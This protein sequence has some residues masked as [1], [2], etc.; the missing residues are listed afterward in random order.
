MAQGNDWYVSSSYTGAISNGSTA[1]P[2]KTL[3]AVSSAAVSGDGIYLQRGDVFYGTLQLGANNI[4]ITSYG[5]PEKPNPKISGL[6]TLDSADFVPSTPL[7]NNFVWKCPLASK[8]T[9]VILNGELLEIGRNPDPESS[10]SGYYTYPTWGTDAT[11]KFIRASTEGQLS[12]TAKQVVIR[13]NPSSIET[14]PVQNIDINNLKIYYQPT[15][16][17]NQANYAFD[18]TNNFGYYFQ[19]DRNSLSRNGEWY[20]DETEQFLYVFFQNLVPKTLQVSTV[21]ILCNLPKGGSNI[22]ITGI[23]F[24]G[25]RRM[26]INVGDTSYN[27]E[28][29]NIHITSC[30]F[31]YIGVRGIRCRFVRD[32]YVKDC[33]FSNCLSGGIQFYTFLFRRAQPNAQVI[34]C[35]FNNIAPWPGMAY[36]T[37]MGDNNAICTYVSTNCRIIGNKFTDVGKAAIYWQGDDVEI[38]E[39]N[40][41]RAMKTYADFGAIYTWTDGA[42]G[43]FENRTIENNLVYDCPGN[44][45]GTPGTSIL[46]NGIYLDGNTMN[47]LVKNNTVFNMPNAGILA[48]N[49]QNITL[50]DNTLYNNRYGI[51]FSHLRDW[52]HNQNISLLVKHNNIYSARGQMNTGLLPNNNKLASALSFVADTASWQSQDLLNSQFLDNAYGF[53]NPLPFNLELYDGAANQSDNNIGLEKW[54]QIA[55]EQE[56]RTFP[57]RAH[58]MPNG[59]GY[60]IAEGATPS[61]FYT[62]PTDFSGWIPTTGTTAIPTPINGELKVELTP[63]VNAWA[64]VRKPFPG[65]S[66]YANRKY[67]FSY[68]V[69]AESGNSVCRSW[70]RIAGGNPVPTSDNYRPFTD[71]ETSVEYLIEPT[72][73]M[74]SPIFIIEIAR[75]GGTV[76]ISDIK[77]EDF[78]TGDIT[79]SNAADFVHF[80]YNPQWNGTYSSPSLPVAATWYEDGFGYTAIDNADLA[81]YQSLILFKSPLV[82]ARPSRVTPPLLFNSKPANSIKAYPNPASNFVTVTGLQATGEWR[83]ASITDS[84]GKTIMTKQIPKGIAN[85]KIPVTLLPR[86]LYFICL[87]GSNK[88]HSLQFIKD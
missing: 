46:S 16:G 80:A 11:G 82:N 77:I 4:K 55:N 36:N 81:P 56:T 40:I 88:R 10:P 14:K 73:A 21:D 42:F 6:T 71:N 52:L 24:E 72:S 84:E 32:L 25:A 83:T 54:K 31:S 15:T 38:K 57:A 64:Q 18:P 53:T 79:V 19:D 85:F 34:G 44:I 33:H 8:P 60:A 50:Q 48:N 58:F 2:F 27:G 66:L 67:V 41:Q 59:Q 68:K 47:V 20:Y 43:P 78:A 69:R 61:I 87:T 28:N 9:V 1:H 5:E 3:A 23:D 70:A 22:H 26:G 62:S 37:D 76:Y 63:A 51:R 30:N 17:F 86:G 7:P 45:A 39:N 35:T 13:T 75:S 12:T 74:L 29:G 49:P 65:L